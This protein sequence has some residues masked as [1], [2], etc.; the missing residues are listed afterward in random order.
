VAARAAVNGA[1]SRLTAYSSATIAGS[2]M[3][4]AAMTATSTPRAASQVT[5]TLR[6]GHRSATAARTRPPASHGRNEPA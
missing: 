3:P 1:S 4:G 2:G 5:R 6:R